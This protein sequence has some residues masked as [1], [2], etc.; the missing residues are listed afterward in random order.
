[1][2]NEQIEK[3]GIISAMLNHAKVQLAGSST[4]SIW[5][6]RYVEDIGMLLEMI[7]D[8][9][10]GAGGTIGKPVEYCPDVVE[11]LKRISET[12]V[13]PEVIKPDRF[14]TIHRATEPM[15]PATEEAFTALQGAL[16]DSQRSGFE[17]APPAPEGLQPWTA[18]WCYYYAK[19][20]EATAFH[21][22]NCQKCGKPIN[23]LFPKDFG[24][25]SFLAYDSE[26]TCF[27]SPRHSHW[28]EAR[29]ATWRHI[30][31]F[32]AYQP[33]DQR[34]IQVSA[35]ML[36]PDGNVAVPPKPPVP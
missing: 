31:D 2:G 4:P 11:A 15:E 12:P 23:L 25:D 22:A 20:A 35:R 21:L 27:D 14:L 32:L 28:K 34:D 1:M 13:K 18:L 3:I 17:L 19:G 10:R 30:S 26:C 29:P 8:T 33:E 36:G 24:P 9:Q 7:R 5:L 16:A 6:R